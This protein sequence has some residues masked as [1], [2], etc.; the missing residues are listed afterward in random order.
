M[1]RLYRYECEAEGLGLRVQTML[2]AFSIFFFLF[3][4][5]AIV[6]G[7]S[8]GEKVVNNASEFVRDCRDCSCRSNPRSHPAIAL[9]EG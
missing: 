8:C 6:I 7:F 3:S 2:R 1:S 9:A 4:K 5:D